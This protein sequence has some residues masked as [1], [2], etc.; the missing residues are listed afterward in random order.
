MRKTK[1]ICTLGPAVDQPEILEQL[2]INGM[3][4]ARLNFSHGTHAEQLER[5]NRLKK[6][7]GK[8]NKPIPLLLDTKGPEIRTKLFKAR[9]VILEENKKFVIYHND[10]EGDSTKCSVTY[11]DLHKDLKEGSRIL[12]NDGLVELKVKT[13]DDKDI[14]CE[15]LNGGVIGNNK[16]INIP[17]VDIQ[18]PSLTEQDEKDIIFGSFSGK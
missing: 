15:V 10:I 5:V 6:I 9:E 11:K 2:V 13:I 18:L 17:D 3:D 4:V 14:Y 1:I 7:R 16:G 8:Y 12:I